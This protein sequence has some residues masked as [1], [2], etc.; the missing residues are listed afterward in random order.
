MSFKWSSSIA[1]NE[2]MQTNTSIYVNRSTVATDWARQI[3]S[4]YW[5][6]AW[7]CYVFL[8]EWTT[9]P[10]K[11]LWL[12]IISVT[13]SLMWCRQ[14]MLGKGKQNPVRNLN[15]VATEDVKK[16]PTASHL[17]KG[18][19]QGQ[20]LLL[21]GTSSIREDRTSELLTWSVL[22]KKYCKKK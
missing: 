18:D 13:G 4:K 3:I 9:D 21:H 11:L 7:I 15:Q 10:W 5:Q 16:L 1:L 17:T 20:L 14:G 2:V 8:I 12:R 22:D 19:S 6:V